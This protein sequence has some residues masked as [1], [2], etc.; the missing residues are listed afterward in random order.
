M[1]ADELRRQAD[2]FVDLA[3]LQPKVGRDPSERST[4]REPRRHLEPKAMRTPATAR[5]D[6]DEDSDH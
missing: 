2:V 6:D 1:V 5:H 4:Q 3:T